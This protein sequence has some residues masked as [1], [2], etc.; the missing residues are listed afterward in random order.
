MTLFART[1]LA[2]AYL[3]LAM[4]PREYVGSEH[5]RR[6]CLDEARSRL[7]ALS[8][9]HLRLFGPG[10]PY[11]V[12]SHKLLC[13]LL[14]WSADDEVALRTA[15]IALLLADLG[16]H[17]LA[18]TRNRS[19]WREEYG[20][21]LTLAVRLASGQHEPALLVE[22]IELGRSQGLP[23]VEPA[24]AALSSTAPDGV[25]LT[26]PRRAGAGHELQVA[27]PVV[28][29][30]RIAVGGV[31]QFAAIDAVGE[32][33]MYRASGLAPGPAEVIEFMHW[34]RDICGE[35]AP[36]VWGWWDIDGEHVW[37]VARPTPGGDGVEVLHDSAWL[38]RNP[39]AP[40]ALSTYAAAL[41]QA[42]E[43]LEEFVARSD[44]TRSIRSERELF[45]ML[46]R[47]I[48][49][50]PV[51]AEVLRRIASGEPALP[52][53]V[54]PSPE[55]S[56]VPLAALAVGD[57]RQPATTVPTADGSPDPRRLVE[58][59][60]L[61]LAPGVQFTAAVRRRYG[62]RWE[63]PDTTRSVRAV[64]A[65][66]PGL[67]HFL[68]WASASVPPDAEY[69]ADEAGASLAAVVQ[70]LTCVAAGSAGVL[71][72]SG[73]AAAGTPE[74]PGAAHL[75]LHGGHG[76]RRERL[77]AGDLLTGRFPHIGLPRCVVLAACSTWGDQG[78]AD[79]LGLAP[80]LMW[81]GARDVV[82]TLWPMLDARETAAHHRQLV[83]RLASGDG[84]SPVAVIR[85]LQLAE[86]GRQRTAT[87][88][89]QRYQITP[90]DLDR[91]ASGFLWA[92]YT[93]VTAGSGQ[94]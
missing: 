18:D 94:G 8:A 44:L 70:A 83:T 91:V 16:R 46:G 56:R 51:G 21:L 57:A 67:P 17:R 92:A 41:Q 36:W 29:G 4:A 65:S 66:Q 27:I 59:A 74:A 53:V 72:F 55:C 6:E 82:A 26:D 20:E 22:A 33:F 42:N 3:A 69:L 24:A 32:A 15:V 12:H 90:A 62:E 68:P 30:G 47:E 78:A 88:L 34:A 50:P 49:P 54:L 86:L 23:A 28:S 14:E 35:D 63:A 75:L 79:W 84:T 77:N 39:A 1:T 52:L 7:F 85:D 93:V 38:Q 5:K 19:G 80:G 11:T 73:H 60:R 2:H 64:V 87:P 48:I 9:D 76:D 89:H 31:S 37:Y 13:S 25:A 43:G 10:H 71:Q 81:N 58:G 40:S 61:H 45:T